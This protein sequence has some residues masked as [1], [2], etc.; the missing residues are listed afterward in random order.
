M[1]SIW[2]VKLCGIAVIHHGNMIVRHR[3]AQLVNGGS[4]SGE[5]STKECMIPRDARTMHNMV[6]M[7]LSGD[8]ILNL[9]IGLVI[10]RS[11]SLV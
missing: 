10:E 2:F 7:E 8:S 4:V 1:T 6:V 11:S 9:A 3:C 5:M